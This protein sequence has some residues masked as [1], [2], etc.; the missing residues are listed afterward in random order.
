MAEKTI[1]IKVNLE[2][3]EAQQKKLVKLERNL[4]TLTKQ[5]TRLNNQLKK[6]VITR[7]QFSRAVAKNNLNLKAHR[8]ELLKTRQ[9]MLGVDSFTQKLGKSFKKMGTSMVAGFAGLFA[10]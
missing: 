2:G 10:I 1:A 6:G 9:Q 7:D 5:R 8:T 3:T 4:V